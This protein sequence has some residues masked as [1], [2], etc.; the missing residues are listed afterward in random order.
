MG[1]LL[2]TLG[3]CLF[4][5]GIPLAVQLENRDRFC[6][7]CHT[8]PESS[9]YY[10]SLVAPN[11]LASTHAQLESS[12]RCIDCHSRQGLGG[13]AGSLQQG[14]HDLME[15]LSNDYVQPAVSHNPIGDE[16]CTKCHSPISSKNSVVPFIPSNSHYHIASYLKEWDARD[17]LPFGTC[18]S[19]HKTHLEI[20][21][22]G[23]TQAPSF[24]LFCEDCHRVLSGWQPVEE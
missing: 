18:A 21:T 22:Q 19:C 5:G 4:C 10:R 12:V 7:S 1:L 9:Y 15:Y 20:G 16:G 23:E 3:L 13:R 6:A 17:P 11:D 14:A 24:N 2:P 8:E